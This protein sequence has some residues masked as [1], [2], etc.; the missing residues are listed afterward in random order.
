MV[1]GVVPDA[2]EG[3]S[4]LPE[5][6]VEPPADPV[7]TT[8]SP[9][10]PGADTVV[11]ESGVPVVDSA[12]PVALTETQVVELQQKLDAQ[13][14]IQGGLD[15]ANTQLQQKVD[16]SQA[17]IDELNAQ[18]ELYETATTGS[19]D[20]IAGFI[21]QLAEA[22]AETEQHSAALEALLVEQ[23]RTRIVME[24]ATDC[25]A[26]ISL[27]ANRALP[28][29]D[30][31]EEFRAALGNLKTTIS[32]AAEQTALSRTQ[33]SRPPASPAVGAP[34]DLDTLKR[35]I[36]TLDPNTPEYKE[37]KRQWNAQVQIANIPTGS[38]ER[39]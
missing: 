21:Q 33:G 16:A 37:A 5:P 34:V 17:K 19:E 20:A 28:Q 31:E 1:L 22:K 27:A 25:P 18:L 13:K 30:T 32:S 23:E 38:P 35:I 15:R 11:A 10:T 7:V 14:K 8:V 6:V 26:L 29:A 36:T 24:E 9:Q 4:G 39:Q 3:P 12:E 2:T